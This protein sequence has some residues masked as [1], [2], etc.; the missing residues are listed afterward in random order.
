[1]TQ[2]IDRVRTSNVVPI[3]TN[4]TPSSGTMSGSHRPDLPPGGTEDDAYD[5]WD[6]WNLG[7]ELISASQDCI[8]VIDDLGHLRLRNPM[9][10]RMLGDDIADAGDGS[11]SMSWPSGVREVASDALAVAAT[12]G[13]AR[14]DGWRAAAQGGTVYWDVVLSRIVDVDG[15]LV[16]VMAVSRDMTQLRRI[17]DGHDLRGRE[18]SHRLKNLFALV[19][20]LVTLSARNLPAVQ[21]YAGTLRDR[22]TAMSRALEYLQIPQADERSSRPQQTLQGLLGALLRPYDEAGGAGRRFVHGAMD[23]VPVGDG[24]VTGLA[25]VIH[26]LATNAIKHGALSGNGG[27]VTVDC[28]RVGGDMR[29]AWTERGGPRIESPP[30]NE[31]FGSKLTERT[32][33]GQLSGTISHHWDAEGLRV[34]IA[35]PWA[36]LAS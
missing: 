25:L 34:V 28:R 36:S 11:W 18:L 35:L 33:R 9:A 5:H 17:E 23:D 2:G 15:R 12:V 19:N 21:S 22:F 8:E 30:R 14:F 26:E 16:G 24:S 7:R 29:I 3:R 20:G 27:T 32:V 1:M 10:R 6:P 13:T 31:G 4:G